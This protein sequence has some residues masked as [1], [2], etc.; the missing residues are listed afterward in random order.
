MK[1]WKIGCIISWVVIVVLVGLGM[2][3]IVPERAEYVRNIDRIENLTWQYYIV[4]LDYERSCVE[5]ELCRMEMLGCEEQIQ[6]Y[7]RDER[8]RE[9]YGEKEVERRIGEYRELEEWYLKGSELNLAK[10]GAAEGMYRRILSE[11]DSLGVGKRTLFAMEEGMTARIGES[12]R[13]SQPRYVLG[14]GWE[15]TGL[16]DMGDIWVTRDS[17]G[18]WCVFLDEPRKEGDLW[19]SDADWWMTG[20]GKWIPGLEKGGCRHYKLVK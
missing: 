13:K 10:A 12:L 5:Y 16:Y 6:K 4:S 17:F 2:V 20:F 18:T 14:E 7:S 15:E 3:F 8:M 19:T 11:L 9:K 1:G